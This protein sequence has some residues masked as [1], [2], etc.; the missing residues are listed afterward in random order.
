MMNLGFNFCPAAILKCG[1]AA[2][3]VLGTGCSRFDESDSIVANGNEP[4]DVEVVFSGNLGMESD[5][6]SRDGAVTRTSVNVSD[7]DVKVE[8]NDTDEVGIF[9]RT[10]DSGLSNYRY[11]AVPDEGDATR[12]SFVVPAESENTIRFYDGVRNDFFAIYPFMGTE[13]EGDATAFEISLPAAQIQPAS[14][15]NSH[16]GMYAVMTADP[17]SREAG[18]TTPVGLNFRNIFSVLAVDVDCSGINE[19]LVS[20]ALYAADGDLA[21]SEGVI[22]MTGAILSGTSQLPLSVSDGSPRINLGFD[23][24]PDLSSGHLSLWFVV[25]PGSH[26]SGSLSLELV[27]ADGRTYTYAFDREVNFVSNK[28]FHKSLAVSDSDF[29]SE[30]DIRSYAIDN[31]SYTDVPIDGKLWT[32]R[33]YALLRDD[34]GIINLPER[35]AGWTMATSGCTTYPAGTIT[36]NQSGYIYVMTRTTYATIMHVMAKDGWS[37]VTPLSNNNMSALRDDSTGNP[38]MVIW[39]KH[40]QSGQTVDVPSASVGWGGYTPLSPDGFAYNY[41]DAEIILHQKVE[42]GGKTTSKAMADG[43]VNMENG[44]LFFNSRCVAGGHTLDFAAWNIP[45]KFAYDEESRWQTLAYKSAYYPDPS[46]IE[47][48]S[49][50]MVYVMIKND[51][52]YISG[53]ESAG[54]KRETSDNTSLPDSFNNQT[55]ESFVGDDAYTLYYNS[56]IDNGASDINSAGYLVL[57]SKFCA[58]GE[59]VDLHYIAKNILKTSAGF[60]C[61]RPVAK[62]L[63]VVYPSAA[64]TVVECEEALDAEVRTF[65]IGTSLPV[66]STGCKLIGEDGSVDNPEWADF[67]YYK[68]N[69]NGL[70]YPFPAGFK[71]F[72]F[73]AVRRNDTQHSSSIV[74]RAE[75]TGLVYGLVHEIYDEDMANAGWTLVS[76]AYVYDWNTNP[77][78]IYS[79]PVTAGETYSTPLLSAESGNRLNTVTLLSGNIELAP[80]TPSIS[81]AGGFVDIRSFKSGEALYPQNDD[82][83]LTADNVP[84]WLSGSK[85]ATSLKEYAGV[86]RM[87]ADRRTVF[88]AAVSP[89]AAPVDG[90]RA[91]GESLNIGGIDFDLC[92]YD[93]SAPDQWIAVPSCEGAASSLVFGR[94]I[95]VYGVP[96]APGSVIAKAP[97]LRA[98]NISNP[99]LMILEDGS[100]LAGCTG[101]DPTGNTFF[102]SY[103]KGAT[104]TRISNPGYMNFGKVFSKDGRLYEL[105]VSDSGCGNI[106]IR[107]SEDFGATWSGT[108]T[109]FAGNYHSAPTPFVECDGRLWHAM[110]TKSDNEMMG[111]FVMSL[112]LQADPMTASSWTM[113]NTIVGNR[114]WLDSGS[115]HVFNQWQEGC[116]VRTPSDE[117][118]IVTRIDDSL[119]NDIMAIID[120]EDANTIS[121]DPASGF[122]IMPGAGKKFTI[123]YDEPSAKY[124]AVTTPVFDEDR[125]RR[126][127]GWYSEKILPIFLRSHLALCSSPD[128]ETWSIEKLVVTSDNVFFHGFQ[129]A[130]WVIDGND[131][132][133]LCRTAF[134][135]SRGLPNRQHDANMLTVHRLHDFRSCGFDTEYVNYDQID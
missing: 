103:D 37:G 25:M 53:M 90:W 108:Q 94:D 44:A 69:K 101:A 117:L 109:L 29:V 105:G 1:I 28:Y 89:N 74:F 31:A 16:V 63:K 111:I 129:Y 59:E 78:N 127:S 119:S 64:I 2:L 54:W 9:V 121:F 124:W 5:A 107:M 102:R 114:S 97:E 60:Q 20:A 33:T 6:G 17:V 82:Y 76:R 126:H 57:M 14:G 4:G 72:D 91:T 120:V 66:G 21:F 134:S 110:G 88:L 71:G 87:K 135:E 46:V 132:V 56:K 70:S 10:S 49:A 18:D 30:D 35:F 3:M 50:G 98:R 23:E 123:M 130:D 79:L 116:V 45:S 7:G 48:V 75:E 85:Y 40:V 15:D 68:V 8:W 93:Y 42:I 96:E 104:W 133:A 26:A 125:T 62:N 32:D 100:Y 11:A 61:I 39:R 92:T 86:A 95:S 73:L 22:D 41:T 51:P 83:A 115:G 36:P 34:N 112:P 55:A 47:A 80:E 122:H 106:V 128:L 99:S 38:A 84:A 58:A 113:S 24:N 52:A 81:V 65:S 13:G 118:K 12:C 67:G 19:S 27:L 77:F 43:I 131:M